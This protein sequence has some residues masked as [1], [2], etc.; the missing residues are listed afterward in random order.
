MLTF[1]VEGLLI[2][3]IIDYL[4]QN[5]ATGHIFV[6][7]N[8]N[9]AALAH[10]L[11][12]NAGEDLPIK[13]IIT[14]VTQLL[15]SPERSGPGSY[16]YN[17]PS[18]STSQVSVLNIMGTEDGLIPYEGGSSAVFGDFKEDFI[19]MSALDSM[20]TWAEHNDCDTTPQITTH[21][22]DKGTGEVI[23]YVYPNCADGI[24]VEHYA[25]IGGGHGA[26]RASI[27]NVKINYDLTYQ[28]IRACESDGGDDPTTTPPPTPP[29]APTAT[30]PPTVPPTDPPTAP[31]TSETTSSC[32]DDPDWHGKFNT[33]H[34]C[35]YIALEPTLRCG[36]QDST[37]FLAEDA[38]P[39]ACDNCTD[40]DPTT[41]PP[42]TASPTA[43]PTAPPTPAT[44]SSCIDDPDWRGKFDSKHDCAYVS[45]NA[46]RCSWEDS[47]GVKAV[48]ACKVACDS[49]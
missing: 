14:K 12:S 40:D 23:K 22:S 8:S 29:P 1:S 19:L 15:E 4:A 24:I 26:G 35:A 42:P 21:G 36:W 28:F 7:G 30:V 13:G 17:Q 33:E 48:D 45:N 44:T 46:A 32:F 9:G 18:A 39:V 2:K 49:C 16:N 31:P 10:R 38:C 5:G 43:P 25:I 34:N 11:A 6:T 20:Q 27:D 47:N 37:G 41:T 3:N